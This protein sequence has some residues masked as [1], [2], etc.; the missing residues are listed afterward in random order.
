MPVRRTPYSTIPAEP[1]SAPFG[2]RWWWTPDLAFLALRAVVGFLLVRHG[3]HDLFGVL[4]LPGERWSGIP[5]PGTE[6]WIDGV[7][8]VL[9]GALVTFGLFTRVAAL[10]LAILVALTHLTGPGRG[11]PLAAGWEVAALYTL[12]LLVFVATGPG[13]FSL[14][15]LV[16]SRV[17]T[18]RRRDTVSLSPWIRKQYRRR[19]LAR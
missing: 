8:L 3:A 17:A 13:M 15:Y 6:P 9:A 4:S 10:I 12:V 18:R 5:A 2:S 11:Q 7:V 1:I 19:E 14:E 16:Q